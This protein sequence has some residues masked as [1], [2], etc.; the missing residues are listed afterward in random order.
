MGV[1]MQS[2]A[3]LQ[4]AAC[5]R[6]M[7]VQSFAAQHVVPADMQGVKALETT[8]CVRGESQVDPVLVE[9]YVKQPGRQS[10]R[11][12]YHAVLADAEERT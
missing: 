9:S 4:G 12:I 3:D 1:K 6:L 5:Q 11:V 8:L 10:S 7:T 2:S